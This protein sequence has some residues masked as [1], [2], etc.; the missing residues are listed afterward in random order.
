[1][2]DQPPETPTPAP[3][4]EKAS[5]PPADE[6]A[7]PDAPTAVDHQGPILLFDGVCNLCDATVQFII[8][9]DAK[10]QF[11]FAAL[12]SQVARRLLAQ[13]NAPTPE[14][15]PDSVVLLDD[16]G[17]HTRSDAALRTVRR[18]RFPYPLLFLFVLIPRFLRD[19][20]YEWIARNRYRWFGRQTVCRI[21]TS[22][23][24]ALFL[25]ADEPTPAGP[26]P[27]ARA[28]E[29]TDGV[30]AT[31]EAWP[32]LLV[33]RFLLVY[34]IVYMLPFPVSLI[35]SLWG[36]PGLRSLLQVEWV[37]AILGFVLGLWGMVTQ[38][39]VAAIGGVFGIEV[40]FRGTGSGD[41]WANWFDFVLDLGLAL[42]IVAA[43]AL[44]RRSKPIGPRVAD[45]GRTLLR[46][47]VATTM[48]GYGLAKTFP[49]QFTVPGPDRLLQPYGDSSPMGLAWTFLGASV[50]YQIFGGLMELL[51]ALLL[52]WRRT[53]LMGALVSAGVLT[54]VF[55]IN[56]FFD[57]PVKLF[58]AHLL[59][60]S[61]I[62]ALP[63]LPRLFAVLLG[64]VTAAP[65]ND[66]PFYRDRPGWIRARRLTKPLLVL[67]VLFTTGWMSWQRLNTSGMLADPHPLRG[68]WIV[69]SFEI[70][71]ASDASDAETSEDPAP[72]ESTEE[73]ATDAQNVAEAAETAKAP[74]PQ[75]EDAV[76]WVRIGL[77]PPF[78]GTVQTA[79]GLALRQR[80][81]VDDEA[82]TLALYDRGLSEPPG[83]PLT[84]ELQDADTLV[85]TGPYAGRNV[86][87]QLRRAEAEGLLTTRGFR[88]VN[89]Y[90][91][92]R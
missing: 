37:G 18:L 48:I 41:R 85:L 77:S 7:T 43:W 15:L 49:V 68:I 81:Q 87:I 40:T 4:E 74:A 59:F 38:P 5:A 60:F 50:G 71:E 63:D 53:T 69:E 22:E 45:V 16:Q 1:M 10:S 70:D 6:A 31:E 27:A 73:S 66:R 21:P 92:N 24:R 3:P 34:P 17:V 57:V 84:F 36:V 65:R 11:R 9:H 26:P 56:L 72:G 83:D 75:V 28:D 58:S 90:P 32:A 14:D 13:R 91:F 20:A 2:T 80:L 25:D 64:N 46:Y 61:L 62:L 19:P 52:L 89:D 82:G 51:G 76:R 30:E 23:E 79:D 44:W 47:Y 35:G 88:W 78:I 33:Q 86:R 55:A 12:Q 39:V 8:D 42:V 29:G 67:L 54:N